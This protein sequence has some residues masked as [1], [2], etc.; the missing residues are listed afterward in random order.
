[1]GEL[2]QLPPRGHYLAHEVGRLAGVSGDRIGQWARYGYIHSSQSDGNPRV[3][4]YQDA[5]E[6]MMV[7]DLLNHDFPYSEIKH[8][9]EQLRADYGD[10][11]LT[12]ADLAAGSGGLL[13]QRGGKHYDVSRHD[14]HQILRVEN[15][16]EIANQLHA[17]GWA[18]RE[19][20]DLRH[21]E[22]DPDRL[23]GRPT[24]RGRRVPVEMVAELGKTD[25]GVE[26]LRDD[27]DLTPAQIRDAQRWWDAVRGFERPV[28]A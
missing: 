14:W 8:A 7:H 11:P 23:S 10:W 12:H 22:V 1:M 21:I 6:A 3:Y 9:I 19:V 16:T 17:G 4:S 26:V 18:V 20:P 25:H 28:A 27:Y 24:I 13:V 5:A 15:P 2:R